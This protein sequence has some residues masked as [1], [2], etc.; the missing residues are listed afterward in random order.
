MSSRCLF[1]MVIILRNSYLNRLYVCL[2]EEESSRSLTWNSE[3]PSEVR[4]RS[5]KRFG[6]ELRRGFRGFPRCDCLSSERQ[7]LGVS[8]CEFDFL[9]QFGFAGVESVDFLSDFFQ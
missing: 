6:V 2:F 5:L 1:D 4:M 3:L 7:S 9:L 8:E